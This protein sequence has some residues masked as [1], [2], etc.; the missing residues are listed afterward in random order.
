MIRLA[1]TA[2]HFDNIYD[3]AQSVLEYAKSGSEDKKLSVTLTLSDLEYQLDKPLIF[4][5]SEHPQL[6]NIHLSICSHNASLF[7]SNRRLSPSKIVQQQDVCR[8]QLKAD[9]N[10]RYPRFLDLY[11]GEGRM[12]LCRSPHFTHVF[13]L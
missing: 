3:A 4:D 13:D 9:E 5:A 7:T 6:K 10:G 1:E 12:K 2:Q 8:Y 11:E